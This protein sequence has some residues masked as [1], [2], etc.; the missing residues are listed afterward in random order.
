MK[1]KLSLFLFLILVTTSLQA[2][3]S[4]CPE[5]LLIFYDFSGNAIDKSGNNYHGI[6][7][8]ATLADD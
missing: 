7:N 8:G 5:N 3:N 6:V 2:N 1:A 4:T